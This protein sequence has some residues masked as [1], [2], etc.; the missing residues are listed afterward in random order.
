VTWLADAPA[1]APFTPVKCYHFDHII[2]KAVLDKDEDFKLFCDHKTEFEFDVLGDHEMR[3]VKKGDIIQISRRGYF[4]CDEPFVPAAAGSGGEKGVLAGSPLVLF[5]IPEGNKR[6]SPTS[7]M[8]LTGQKY[9]STEVAEEAELK[10]KLEPK[11]DSA[12]DKK[13]ESQKKEPTPPRPATAA[14]AGYDLAKAEAL[15]AQIKDKGEA[16]RNLKTQKAAKV[17]FLDL[18]LKIRIFIL[19]FFNKS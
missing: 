13:K 9:R 1:D 8:S 4:I 3:H 7:Y 14:A 6:E 2:S 5:N 19:I 11:Q 16:V 17:I 12:A 18:F 10:A 15:S